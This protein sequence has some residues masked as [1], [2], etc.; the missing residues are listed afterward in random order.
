MCPPMN[1]AVHGPHSRQPPAALAP[2]RPTAAPGSAWAPA[3]ATQVQQQHKY[4][5]V[6]QGR[7]SMCMCSCTS[8]TS[9]LEHCP[10]DIWCCLCCNAS[11]HIQTRRKTPH[12]KGMTPGGA[13]AAAP[14]RT[15]PAC[16]R[17]RTRLPMRMPRSTS[18]ALPSAHASRL[19]VKTDTCEA[20]D[21]KRGT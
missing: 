20:R 14:S 18:A 16:L 2:V 3:A 17:S 4:L 9:S 5:S 10:G 11:D 8:I 12:T 15:V 1:P 7:N 19:T 21:Q 13:S 6:W